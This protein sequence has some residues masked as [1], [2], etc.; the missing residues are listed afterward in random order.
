[1]SR[2]VVIKHLCRLAFR[3]GF[4]VSF[5]VILLKELYSSMHA[6]YVIGNFFS[7]Y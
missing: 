5:C 4:G 1:M 2:I 3:M 6:A 7:P